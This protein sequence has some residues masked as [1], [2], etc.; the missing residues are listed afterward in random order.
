MPRISKVVKEVHAVRR[1]LYNKI[2][3]MTR[4]ERRK[5]IAEQAQAAMAR[6]GCK[7]RYVTPEEEELL[8]SRM[9]LRP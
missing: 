8:R 4:E 5:Y 9:Q 3:D 1:A 7:I 6:I 2:K